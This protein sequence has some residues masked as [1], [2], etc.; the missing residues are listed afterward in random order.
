MT[1]KSKIFLTSTVIF[2]IQG[3]GNE[4]Q[5]NSIKTHY[6][7]Q[8]PI[9]AI[10]IGS[11]EL[12]DESYV[13]KKH[14]RSFTSSEQ[15][16]IRSDGLLYLNQLRQKNNMIAFSS[17]NHLNTSAYN[18]SH[19]LMINNAGGH[20]ESS[21]DSGYTGTNPSK[22]AIY[23]GYAHRI[24]GEN[25]SMGNDS[26][27]NS[28]D[29]LFSAIYHRFGFLSFLHDQVGI[30]ADSSSSHP[31]KN[32]YTY[33]LGISQ[34]VDAC[35]GVS[36]SSGYSGMCADTS[37]VISS[38][39]YQNALTENKNTNP[40]YAIWPYNNQQD[41]IPVFYE[42]SPDPLPECSVSGYPVSI[43]F[44]DQK[45]SQIQMH[46]FKL[47]YEDNNSEITNTKILDE[48]TDPNNKL[49]SYEY[50]LFP[51]ER[52]RFDTKYRAEFIYDENGET[53]NISWSFKTKTL[54]YP[55]YIVKDKDS[56]FD[57]KSGQTYLF[58][59][60]PE[61]CNDSS[62]GYS[63]SYSGNISSLEHKIYDF[64]TIEV[65]ATGDNGN[66]TVSPNNGRNFTLH[67]TNNDTA[68]YPTPQQNKIEKDLNGDGKADILLR[69]SS[70][71]LWSYHMN[72][73]KVLNG[74]SIQ[75]VSNSWKVV[76]TGD[77]NGDGKSDIILRHTSGLLW[78]YLMDGR[79]ILSGGSIKQVSNSWKVIN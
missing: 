39:T 59:L 73:R 25:L 11:V 52:L 45:N 34:M 55:Y 77:L 50:A 48:Q 62:M 29:G 70:G 47:Y 6:L 32:A 74:G 9:K 53:K 66:I 79:T 71:L 10:P 17:E 3:C 1:K 49:S 13:I 16:N 19:Y 64:N 20:G 31:Y 8:Q 61:N 60:P 51:L 63:M 72:G 14:S 37:F 42:E 75:Q 38:E 36:S 5:H 65:T 35:S 24:V 2:F 27:K 57:I 43:N 30:G 56:N 67:I 18:H 33:N 54:E 22:R 26:V 68:I 78:G 69:H 12:T 46:S 40:K 23:A 44:N 21:D 28:I 58:Y 41:S 4:S 7:E 15:N 76:G